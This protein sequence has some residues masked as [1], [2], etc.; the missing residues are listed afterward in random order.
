MSRS[1]VAGAIGGIQIPALK[2]AFDGFRRGFISLR[3]DGRVL[4][5]F[6]GSFNDVGAAKEAALA[7]ISQGADLLM[8]DADAAGLGVFDAAAEAHI[9]AFGY[10]RNQNGVAP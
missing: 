4:V 6:I 5:S 1:G 8:H 2:V 10:S 9:Y 3:P 7:Q